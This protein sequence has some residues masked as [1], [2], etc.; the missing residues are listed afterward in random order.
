[1]PEKKQ[2]TV[3]CNLSDV[4]AMQKEIERLA[5]TGPENHLLHARGLALAAKMLKLPMEYT[6]TTAKRLGHF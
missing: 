6:P 5:N 2:Q 3:N 4:L 1:M